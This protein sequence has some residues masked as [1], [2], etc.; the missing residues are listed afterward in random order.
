MN[1]KILLTVLGIL[2]L[3]GVFGSVRI[4]EAPRATPSAKQ[5]PMVGVI[6]TIDDVSPA[7]ANSIPSGTTL[8]AL[9]QS[10]S[11]SAGFT[12]KTKEYAGM[13]T[14]ITALGTFE[15]GADKKYWHYYVNGKLAPVGADAYVLQSGDTIEWKFVAPDSSL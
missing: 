10:V 5:A 11:K 12:M 3:L 9:M 7:H 6:L 1:K 8:L 13:G 14:L 4:A 2:I 15:N